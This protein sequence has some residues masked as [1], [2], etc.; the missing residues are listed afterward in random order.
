VEELNLIQLSK[1]LSPTEHLTE[2]ETQ[3]IEK[4]EHGAE[5]YCMKI[6]SVILLE[7]LKKCQVDFAHNDRTKICR[8]I[9]LL[10]GNSYHKI[11]NEIQKGICFSEYHAEQI[12]NANKV[13]ADLKISISICKDIQ[14]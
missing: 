6:Q 7:I 11:R 4:I 9:A 13:L 5:K 3:I 14:Y 12:D 8:L 10:T 2:Q 1:E